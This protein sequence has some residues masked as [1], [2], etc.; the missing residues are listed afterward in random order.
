MCW[1]P[2]LSQDLVGWYKDLV[3]YANLTDANDAPPF[4]AMFVPAKKPGVSY[5]GQDFDIRCAV[6]LADQDRI[7][8]W[9]IHEAG[10]TRVISDMMG[11]NPNPD[12]YTVSNETY[13]LAQVGTLTIHNL[14][15]TDDSDYYCTTV[16]NGRTFNESV[17]VHVLGKPEIS[18]PH[19]NVSVVVGKNVSLSCTF[20][21]EPF[22]RSS[23]CHWSFQRDGYDSIYE[24]RLG[25]SSRSNVNL[26]IMKFHPWEGSYELNISKVQLNDSGVYTCFL[27]N[28]VGHNEQSIRL[29]VLS[30]ATPE[31]IINNGNND[32]IVPLKATYDENTNHL[33]RV[34]RPTHSIASTQTDSDDV[35][36][37]F[38][39]T[40]GHSAA[41]RAI[42][43]ADMHH[44][45]V[46]A[47][48]I[49]NITGTLFYL[50][51]YRLT[52]MHSGNYSII[53][54]DC[55]KTKQHSVEIK[56]TGPPEV[57]AE[58]T[59]VHG[60]LHRNLSLKCYFISN[61]PA[62]DDV[63]WFQNSWPVTNRKMK[64]LHNGYS[65]YMELVFNNFNQDDFGIYSCRV[66]NTDGI[67]R[68]ISVIADENECLKELCSQDCVNEQGTYTCSCFVGFKMKGN[69]ECVDVDECEHN[70]GGCD[71]NCHNHQGGFSCECNEGYVEIQDGPR[72]KC[73][74]DHLASSTEKPPSK[75]H[76]DGLS[77]ETIRYIVIGAS[78][79]GGMIL[80]PI[81]ICMCCCFL[82]HRK[83]GRQCRNTM[84]MF[85]ENHGFD[86][87]GGVDSVHMN[88]Y[89]S[90]NGED[91]FPRSRLQMG[92][93]I[94]EGRF[95]K[96]MSAKALNITGSSRWELVAVKTCK[97]VGSSNEKQNLLQELK[98]LKKIPH[99]I[100]V[101]AYLGCCKKNDPVFII[102]EY[103]ANGNLQSYLRR[104]RPKGS[105]DTSEY[106]APM[107]E[108]CAKD[109]AMFSLQIAKG[110]AHVAAQGIIHRDLAARN[111]LVG[112]DRVCKITDFGLARD[113]EENEVYERCSHV[114]LPIRWMS[115]E[116]LK[117]NQ[118]TL[119][120]DVWSYGV[121]LW[122]IVTLGATPYP[123]MST[124]DVIDKVSLGTWLVQPQHCNDKLYS[125]M[126]DCWNMSSRSRPEFTSLVK[127]LDLLLEEEAEYI[128]LN[129]YDGAIY[130]EIDSIDTGTME[131]A[132]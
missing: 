33:P 92:V 28:E 43:L 102:L 2:A 19:K 7:F 124:P 11:Y 122:E 96:V 85:Y 37:H 126:T 112:G 88:H 40:Y 39:G 26:K 104:G 89:S 56:V 34:I 15:F 69:R 38:N 47:F 10:R 82:R 106:S 51:I 98:I 107:Y 119:K 79:A 121:L 91:E 35:T 57:S 44:S 130:S 20:N 87:R 103:V 8:A 59:Y 99:H 12:K 25:N 31:P 97:G 131:E 80:L 90:F 1:I 113:T 129:Q 53:G 61:P 14:T 24:K 5:V 17:R 45:S 50:Q 73:V 115:P 118:C 67:G 21:S 6:V 58:E 66:L 49:S 83:K 13:Y 105:A 30:K 32:T 29:L 76:S 65:G 111:I 52:L 16:D 116:A 68:A 100:N 42:G 108:H 36:W 71:N 64:A 23:N 22:P 3:I 63:Y 18:S 70:N 74:E 125:I 55:N 78:V 101:V 77:S 95:G 132:E 41:F 110:M 120:S 48:T 86:P 117:N 9:Q 62:F 84:K 81:S 114:P 109:L 127:V 94:G 4:I 123:G 27:E 54:H 75:D 60:Y 93:Q 72:T 128:Q 46:R